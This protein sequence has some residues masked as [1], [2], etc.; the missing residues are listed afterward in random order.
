MYRRWAAGSAPTAGSFS[1][2]NDTVKP[3]AGTAEY[4]VIFTPTDTN[5]K[6]VTGKVS[7]NVQKAALTVTA[8]N[9]T[10]AYGGSIQ[11]GVGQVTAALVNGDELTE[12]QVSVSADAGDVGTYTGAITVTGAK[13]GNNGTDV[14]ANYEIS[15]GAGDLTISPLT[16]TVTPDSGQSKE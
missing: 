8:N 1:W 4:D 11:A 3:G 5:Y 15:Y 16:I 13:I 7:V 12:V 10:I 6:A 14:T 2:K 9:Q